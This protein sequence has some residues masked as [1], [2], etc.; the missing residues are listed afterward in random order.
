E[1][2]GSVHVTATAVRKP[3]TIQCAGDW[4]RVTEILGQAQSF[5]AAPNGLGKLPGRG[6]RSGQTHQRPAPQ[7]CGVWPMGCRWQC[8][9]RDERVSQ[10]GLGTARITA[11]D[12]R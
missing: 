5:F 11:D 7:P 4:R 10:E 6:E 9:E 3:Q 1:L 12:V 8:V 2:D